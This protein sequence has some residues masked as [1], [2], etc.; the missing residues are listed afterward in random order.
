MRG[1]A[2]LGLA[3]DVFANPSSDAKAFSEEAE[4]DAAIGVEK[5]GPPF[6]IPGV[7]PLIRLIGLYPRGPLACGVSIFLFFSLF[8]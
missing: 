7:E 6:C 3:F 1:P 4:T 2:D 5:V 8:F